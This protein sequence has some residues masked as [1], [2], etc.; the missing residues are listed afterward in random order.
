MFVE[1]LVRLKQ[2]LVSSDAFS[3]K[4]LSSC[5]GLPTTCHS[6]DLVLSEFQEVREHSHLSFLKLDGKIASLYM[7]RKL[8]EVKLN[9]CLF[10]A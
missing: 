8:E 5:S 7:K 10:S 3:F 9:V 6:K 4:Q 2:I 1:C